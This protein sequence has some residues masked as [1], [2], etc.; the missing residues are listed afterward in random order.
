M[1]CMLMLTLSLA[2]CGKKEE[3]KM[4]KECGVVPADE[5]F[6]GYC[7]KC[8]EVAKMAARGER[9]GAPATAAGQNN[10]GPAKGT[11]PSPSPSNPPLDPS[12]LA[13]G[14][15]V[16]EIEAEDVDGVKFKLSDYRGK[17][18]VLDFWGDW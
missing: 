5:R 3:T 14:M 13:I 17:V 18:V 9:M 7:E 12:K 1:T 16:P 6:N 4:C 10:P 11:A 8:F 2:S 15:E